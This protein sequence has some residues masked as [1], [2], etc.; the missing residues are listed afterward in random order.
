MEKNTSKYGCVTIRRIQPAGEP[1]SSSRLAC[2]NREVVMSAI[3]VQTIHTYTH[4]WI[5]AASEGHSVPAESAMRTCSWPPAC[6]RRLQQL[7]QRGCS[8]QRSRSLATYQNWCHQASPTWFFAAF[9][10]RVRRLQH[11]P[12]DRNAK[13]CAVKVL[14]SVGFLS[15]GVQQASLVLTSMWTSVITS[16]ACAAGALPFWSFFGQVIPEG[17]AQ[18]YQ[19]SQFLLAQVYAVAVQHGTSSPLVPGVL[20]F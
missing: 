5:K 8:I 4:L 18:T 12:K 7:K 16:P 10:N 20:G 3:L 9:W 13:S 2:R 19:P 15:S 14:N 17:Q 11:Q 6:D 1:A